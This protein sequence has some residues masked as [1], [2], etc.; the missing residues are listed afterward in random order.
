MLFAEIVRVTVYSLVRVVLHKQGFT[1][2]YKDVSKLEQPNCEQQNS[3]K[4]Q[5]KNI[6]TKDAKSV[7]ISQ[8]R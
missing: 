4:N 6:Q 1:P 3:N 5:R 2:L 7:Q 8:D